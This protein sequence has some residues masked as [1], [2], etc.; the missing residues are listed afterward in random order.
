MI[1]SLISALWVTAGIIIGFAMPDAE[2]LVTTTIGFFHVPMAISMEVAFLVAAWYGLRSLQTRQVKYDAL[3]LGFAE[4]GAWL[5]VIAT[6]TG[7][8]WAHVNWN[9]YWNW[10]PQQVGIVATLLTYA[11]LF[12]LRSAVEDEDKQRTLWAVYAIFGF[13]SALFWTMIFRVLPSQNSL[14]PTGTLVVSSP[15]FK[16]VLW[17]N[18]VG[19]VMIMVRL[20]LLRAGLEESGQRIKN[21]GWLWT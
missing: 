2:H 15:A 8:I 14:H 18:V 1:F 7:S 12:A 19:Y 3:S 4:V 17:F 10:D 20:A 21:R 11:A 16:I 5:G 9:T 6:I 13:I